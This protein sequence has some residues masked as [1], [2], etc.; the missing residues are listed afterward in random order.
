MLTTTEALTAYAR[1]INNLDSIEFE[2]LLDEN[3]S[4]ES[5]VVL[6][7]I[8]SRREF[9]EYIRQKLSSIKS[10]R[11]KIF[12]ELAELTA[13]GQNNC[14]VIAQGEKDNLVASIYIKVNANK[15]SKIDVCLIPEPK[16]AIRSGI[17]PT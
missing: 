16:D 12:A 5:Q 15:I 8:H 4:Y 11:V 2:S 3:L 14:V 10:A 17:Y 13:Y 6:T 7:P 9:V 1:M